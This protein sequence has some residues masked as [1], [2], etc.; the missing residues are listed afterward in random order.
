M[1]YSVF[2]RHAKEFLD[3][4]KLCAVTSLSS[5]N[6]FPLAQ[7][8]FDMVIIDEA[9]Q[10]DIASAIP[11]IMRAKQLV[12]IGDPMQLR[13]ISSVKTDEEQEIKKHLGL[14]GKPYIKYAEH[15]LWDYCQ[16]FISN[17]SNGMKVPHMLT[18]HY[19]CHPQIIGYS[20]EMFY[21]G[22]MGHKLEVCTNTSRLKADPKGIVIVDVKGSQVNDN[23]NINEKEVQMSIQLA[24]RT[25][26]QYPDATIGIVTP[27]RHQAEKINSSI[28][29]QYVQQIEANTVHKYQGDE[30]DVMI[31]SLVVTTNSPDKKIGWI[32]NIVPNLVN[33]AVTR[34]KSTL[35]VVCNVDYIKSHSSVNK[36]LGHLIRYNN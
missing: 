20:N 33:V 18:G 34:A 23:I 11:L 28:P 35:Y 1:E 5:K 25:A 6:A 32:D 24:V 9:S 19:R 14:E 29:A 2:T 4:F 27:F 31:Y 13:H 10:C 3:I 26:Q 8:L 15:S 22:Q 36:P 7:E 16:S 21:E 30:K 17:A 12:V